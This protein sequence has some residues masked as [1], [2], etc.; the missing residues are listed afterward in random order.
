MDPALLTLLSEPEAA[1]AADAALASLKQMEF[2]DAQLD[3]LAQALDDCEAECG[4]DIFKDFDPSCGSPEENLAALEQALAEA[5]ELLTD[6]END[7][8][9]D[10]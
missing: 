1:A 3:S 9:D 8:R 7:D 2:F 6:A 10:E 4:S 5:D